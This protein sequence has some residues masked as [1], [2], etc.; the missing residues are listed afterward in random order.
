M[1]Q[2]RVFYKGL[3]DS[4]DS[5]VS[6]EEITG[7]ENMVRQ[8]HKLNYHVVEESDSM[9]MFESDSEPKIHINLIVKTTLN[10][11][12][13]VN[14][15]LHQQE[16]CSAIASEYITEQEENTFEIFRVFKKDSIFEMERGTLT[17][18]TVFC[19][20]NTAEIIE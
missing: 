15:Y 6:V 9:C 11:Q 12:N 16:W 13:V 8:E 10:L 7:I 1:S 5:Y 2:E 17:H 18:A 19:T 4:L 20:K 14:F 3:R